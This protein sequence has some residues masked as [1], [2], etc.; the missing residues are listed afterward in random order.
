[1]RP[2]LEYRKDVTS[3]DGED[4]IIAEIFNRV[5]TKNK[6]CA[7]FGALNGTHDS[8]TWTLLNNEGWSG[9]LIEADKTYFEKLQ[10]VYRDNP[11]A[12]LINEFITY[13][14]EHSL[15]TI[16]ARTPA[17]RD[18][19][20]LSI[21][22]D[23]ADYHVWDSLAQYKPRVVVIEYNPTI[24]NHVE[25]VQPRDMAVFQC[26]SLLSTIELGKKKGYEPVAVN[27]TNVFFVTRELYSLCGV[28]DNSIA[29]LRPHNPFE[30]KL[31]QLYDG[32]LMISG[33]KR[34]FWHNMQIDE[35]KLQVLPKRKRVYPARI[36]SEGIIRSLK[37]HVR[38]LPVH[39]LLMKI[40]KLL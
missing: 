22:I 23:G 24:P 27:E 12:H 38:K 20:L 19:D 14:G 18:F 40:K 8:N 1:M 6:W 26:S 36:A 33:Y 7:E 28:E 29:A 9:V 11:R 34:L 3:Q 21:D 17:P 15:D 35:E 31:F 25:F 30:T 13:E 10:E 4:G 16:F 37:Y 5:G 32:T 2:L 39:P